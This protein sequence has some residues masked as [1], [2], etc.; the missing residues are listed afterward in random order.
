MVVRAK[1]ARTLVIQANKPKVKR[2]RGKSKI[3][4]KGTKSKLISIKTTAPIKRL[5]TP[6]VKVR[7]GI[8]LVVTISEVKLIRKYLSRVFI[9]NIISHQPSDFLAYLKP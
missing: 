6:P 4:S 5:F 3:L 8:I 9:I 2:F 7:P 1:R